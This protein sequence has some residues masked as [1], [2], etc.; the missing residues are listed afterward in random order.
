MSVKWANFSRISTQW[1]CKDAHRF[2]IQEVLGIFPDGR[3]Y[4]LGFERRS[5]PIFEFNNCIVFYYQIFWKISLEGPVFIPLTPSYLLRAS[6]VERT[7]CSQHS[8]IYFTFLKHPTP[9]QTTTKRK[10]F[11]HKK[12]R[13]ENCKESKVRK[14][15]NKVDG[16]FLVSFKIV[17]RDLLYILNGERERERRGLPSSV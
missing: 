17:L 9:P 10:V 11:R 5:A 12:A 3:S 6:M 16:D 7:F 14:R 1:G 4:S 8:K 2:K 15:R 13:A